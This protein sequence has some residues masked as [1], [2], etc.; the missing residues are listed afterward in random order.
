MIK[1]IIID[2]ES[3]ARDLLELLIH[4]SGRAIK[5]VAKCADMIQGLAAIKEHQPDVVF[6]DIEMPEISGLQLLE[7]IPN[8]NFEIIFATAYDQYAI[9]AFEL[10]ALDYLL[11]PIDED[12]LALSIDRLGKK[13][14]LRN[15]LLTY[16]QNQ[17]E[18]EPVKICIPS[19]QK[20]YDIVLV[21]D[22]VAVEASR[23]YSI[24]HTTEQKFTLSKS[25]SYFVDQYLPIKGFMRTHRSWVVNLNY[26]QKLDKSSKEIILPH[27]SIPV[28]RNNYLEVKTQ[29]MKL[30]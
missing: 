4:E 17:Q 25:L 2:D 22:I 27:L 9:K 7:Y 8:P 30:L 29:L 24:I 15:R 11:K 16:E 5:V 26:A 1:A 21:K 19:S 12:K 14:D 3:K 6:L 10:S 13:V 20:D 23:N 28:S 18:G